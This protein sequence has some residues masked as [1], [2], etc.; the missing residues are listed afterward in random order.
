MEYKVFGG[1]SIES[2]S[3]TKSTVVLNTKGIHEHDICKKRDITERGAG[4]A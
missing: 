3:S 1:L 2:T 4:A